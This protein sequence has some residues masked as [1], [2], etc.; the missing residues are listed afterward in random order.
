MRQADQRRAAEAAGRFTEMLAACH[1]RLR[2]FRILESRCRT[3][4]G[5][6]DLIGRR[7]KLLV[8]AEVKLRPS[9][10][11]AIDALTPRQQLRIRRAAEWYL[12]R[13]PRLRDL[14]LRFDLLAFRPWRLPVHVRDVWRDRA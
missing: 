9:G 12:A 8:F 2:G 11:A 4:L 3:P 10:S 14:D 7:G 13:Q 6:I 1:L 5:E